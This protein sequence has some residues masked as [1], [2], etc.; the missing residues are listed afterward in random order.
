M[1]DYKSFYN[2]LLK[3]R[4]ITPVWGYIL[5]MIEDELKIIEKDKYLIIFSIYFS[6]IG[7]G[8]ICISL[9]KEQLIA[10]WIR[11]LEST[12]ILLFE[13]DF[14]NEEEFNEYLDFTMN[15]ISE[16]LDEINEENLPEIIGKNKIF[17]IDNGWLYLKKYFIAR[18]GVIQ[19][20]DRIF[21]KTRNI[22]ST[23]SY[24]DFVVDNFNLT[25]GQELAV[26]KGVEKNLIITG[27]PG[28]GKTTSILFLL[29]NL[30]KSNPYN[31]NVYLVA[32]SGKASSRM[33]ESIIKGL[34]SIKKEYKDN[35][36]EV[37]EKINKLEES[38]IHRLLSIDFNTNGFKYNKNNQFEKNS[39]FVIDEASMIDVCIF[40]ALLEAIPDEAF[41]YIMGDKDQLPSVDCGAVFGDLLNKES[42]QDNIVE[43]D[44][45]RRFEKGSKVYNLAAAINNGADLGIAE[46]EWKDYDTF[47]IINKKIIDN[48]ETPVYFYN[49]EKENCKSKEIISYVI[50]KWGKEFFSQLQ[51]MSSNISPN[52]MTSLLEI[53]NKDY[54]DKLKIMINK[55]HLEKIDGLMEYLKILFEFSEVSKILCAENK[56]P[57]GVKTINKIICKTFIETSQRTSIHGYY[58]GM[59]MMINKNNKLLDLYNGDSGLLVT[60]ENDD[61]LYFM[62]KKKTALV[63]EEGKQDDKIFKLGDFVFYPL[64]LITQS[65]IDLAYAITIHKSQGSDYENILVILPT[66]K[67]HPLLNRQIVYTAI[68]RTKRSTYILSNQQRLDEA[69]ECIVVRDTNIV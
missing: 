27:G 49:I 30:L 17:L 23:E 34:N 48:K 29:I 13:E 37:F 38:T 8:N 42:I 32:P 15:C 36:K 54:F 41:V 61:T 55:P 10:K 62:V 19:S 26:V 56:G 33:K 1:N 20:I 7:D 50:D 39:L 60:F 47:E 11:K 53:M 9:E 64:R 2:F 4:L 65:E 14:Y 68:T 52:S 51:L 25:F 21:S 35:N 46:S 31:F 69:K 6:L 16:Y 67:G 63:N 28:T 22:N 66:A 59:I 40:N 57:R 5:Q 44:V 18:K 58:P 12:R 45:S 43:L 3:N 24:K